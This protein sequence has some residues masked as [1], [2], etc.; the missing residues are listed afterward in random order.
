MCVYIY[1]MHICI[2]IYIYTYLSLSLSLSIYIY[3]AR[4][5]HCAAVSACENGQQWERALDLLG[6][7]QEHA[8]VLSTI[9]YS[10]A[11]SARE[12]GQQCGIND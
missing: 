2:Y 4:G 9:T 12:K 10:A 11:I 3:I 7:M 5:P 8:I 1:I 6:E